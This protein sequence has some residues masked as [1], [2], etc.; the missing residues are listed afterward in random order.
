[1][2]MMMPTIWTTETNHFRYELGFAHFLSSRTLTNWR[3]C[4][5]GASDKDEAD[6]FLRKENKIFI[7]N[8]SIRGFQDPVWTINGACLLAT[9]CA[10]YGLASLG[11]KL[12]NRLID[13]F[14]QE[15]E[16]IKDGTQHVDAAR[17]KYSDFLK[18]RNRWEEVVVLERNSLAR[19]NADYLQSDTIDPLGRLAHALRQ[20][21]QTQEAKM[22]AANIK[23]IGLFGQEREPQ[24][25]EASRILEQ[26]RWAEINMLGPNS[27]V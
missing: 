8:I 18:D 26:I 17:E 5:W 9:V 4:F 23:A 20:T 22:I 24:Q 3:K 11:D 13:G 21:H 10:K 14:E 25:L 19:V 15:S 16:Q 12:F 27:I 1:M 2:M 6:G 7:D